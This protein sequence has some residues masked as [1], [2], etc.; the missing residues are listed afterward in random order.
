[1]NNQKDYFRDRFVIFSG[2]K[3]E[4]RKGQDLVIR[5][6]AILQQRHKDVMLIDNWF[7]LWAWNA[8]S[9]ANSRHIQVPAPPGRSRHRRQPAHG[10]Q[11][12]RP[13]RRHDARHRP[14]PLMAEIYKNTDI[15]LFPQSLRR[16]HQPGDDGIH[17]LRQ[18]RHRRGSHWTRLRT[19]SPTEN[20]LPLRSNKAFT[21]HDEKKTPVG[22]WYEPS[23]DEIVEKLEWAYQN[24]DALKPIA[25]RTAEDLSK[26]TWA[27]TGRKFHQL[28]TE[29]K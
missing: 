15:A 1:M 10:P 18:T 26:L 5:A 8:A 23:L 4:Y 2:G 25:N 17:G 9:I 11:R 6:F 27:E 28:L 7:N 22:T 13:L 29:R 14:N 24:R 20:S 12:H 19:S 16:R 3:L 21:V